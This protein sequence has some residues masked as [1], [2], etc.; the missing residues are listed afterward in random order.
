MCRRLLD[1][2]TYRA[3]QHEP[4]E[5]PQEQ[6]RG[7]G[8]FTRAGCRHARAGDDKLA[9]EEWAEGETHSEERTERHEEDGHAAAV[10]GR[11]RRRTPPVSTPQ[12]VNNPFQRR[13]RTRP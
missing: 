4:A 5:L 6:L 13:K 11:R 3:G 12:S 8:H 7:G 2:G 1:R 9:A 10:A